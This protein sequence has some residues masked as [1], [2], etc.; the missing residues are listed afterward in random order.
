MS[1]QRQSAP[2]VSEDA[3]GETAQAGADQAGHARQADFAPERSP[4]ASPQAE[5]ARQIAAAARARTARIRSGPCGGDGGGARP[6]SGAPERS[7]RAPAAADRRATPARVDEASVPATRESKQQTED[8]REATRET[9]TGPATL[10]VEVPAMATQTGTQAAAPGGAPASDAAAPSPRRAPAPGADSGAAGGLFARTKQAIAAERI[11]AESVHAWSHVPRTAEEIG[12]AQG[13]VL[14]R[15]LRRLFRFGT[16]GPAAAATPAASSALGSI[17][18]SG[19]RRPSRP[20]AARARNGMAFAV[21]LFTGALMTSL[22]FGGLLGLPDGARTPK[23]LSWSLGEQE[24]ASAPAAG[25]ET[26][27]AGLPEVAGQG[28]PEIALGAKTDGS[29]TVDVAGRAANGEPARAAVV[30]VA[31]SPPDTWRQYYRLGHRLHTEGDLRAAVVMYQQAAAF[32]PDD[33]AMLYDWGRALE[34]LGERDAAIEKYRTARQLAPQSPTGGNA[35]A[36][37]LELE[38]K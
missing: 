19:A 26:V 32:E 25:A 16:A 10:E 5:R 7:G 28:G 38:A 13:S 22:L 33:A 34:K 1:T 9:R 36:R 24:R 35:R 17:A 23:W 12:A 31:G 27:I 18:P 30:A 4:P 14:G 37:L 2:R 29:T 3:A 20:A 6:G 8:R 15:V 11:E 21:A